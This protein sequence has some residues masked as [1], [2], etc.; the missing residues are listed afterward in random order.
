VANDV[1]ITVGGVDRSGSAF[2][3]ATASEK[4]LERATQ[5]LN[6]VGQKAAKALSNGFKD[7]G[8]EADNAGNKTESFGKKFKGAIHDQAQQGVD[9]LLGK[10]GQTGAVLG[11]LGGVGIAAG[12]AIGAGLAVATLAANKLKEAFDI[13]VSRDTS[14]RKL[15]AQL[16]LSPAEMKIAGKIAGQVYAD[17]FGESIDDINNTIKAVMQNM[18]GVAD[19]SAGSVK[20]MTEEISTLM[21]T[22][23]EDAA[24]ISR[25]ASQLIR[26]GLVDDPKQAFDLIQKGFQLGDDKAQDLLDTFNEYGTQFRKLGLDGTQALGLIDQAIKAG[27]RDSDVAADALKEFAIRAVDGSTTTANGFKLLGLNA[28]DM[29][30]AIG[31]G[32]TSASGALELTLN[33]LR[34]IKD[35]V[36]QAQAA[37]ALFGTQA[38]DLG[39]SLYAMNLDTAKNQMHDM[40]GATKR[41]SD[42]MSGGFGAA[43]ETARRKIETLKAQLGEKLF[44]VV[45][46][47]ID[48]IWPKMRE[49]IALVADKF[50]EFWTK[51]GPPLINMLHNLEDEWNKNKDSIEK[52][53]P[54]LE[55]LGTFLGVTL[56]AALV[57]VGGLIGLF[58]KYLAGV[59]D[60]LSGAKKGMDVFAVA[61]LTWFG[62]IIDG[63]VEAFGWIPGIGPK[64]KKAQ[65]DFHKFAAG[66]IADVEGIP[67]QHIT[68]AR[69]KLDRG[70][71]YAARD[72][73]AA[74]LGSQ[75]VSVGLSAR[76]HAVGGVAS[77]L[78]RTGEQGAEL[79]R[80]PQ[81]SMVYPAANA[82]Q[83]RAQGSGSVGVTIRV[84][85]PSGD[86]LYEALKE[87]FRLGKVRIYQSSIVPG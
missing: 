62:R 50:Q 13:A 35:P 72:A 47:F 8:K 37:V 36:K 9:G 58:I 82:N 5:A 30:T 16:G 55:Y 84:E 39:A 87:A 86:W 65:A 32:G 71:L 31:K 1:T 70:S 20:A 73:I 67:E 44:P 85:G 78:I 23:G 17:N 38:E 68:D 4:K 6:D 10:L 54:F 7:T 18:K 48:N 51:S 59:G 77:G 14:N 29:A 19:T 66:V 64:L 15:G 24:S 53:K 25:A 80:T 57:V 79:I 21:A 74:V 33:K 41:A 43:I 49:G 2:D 83:M 45:Q 34:A 46:Y 60:T 42:T 56:V 12:A 69:V 75:V 26:T 81:G 27:A 52:L 11:K 40:E 61:M 3:S 76:G 63:A 28:K 22:T